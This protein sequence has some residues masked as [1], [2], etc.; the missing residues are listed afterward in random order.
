[1]GGG[2]IHHDG[3]LVAVRIGVD[4]AHRVFA[5]LIVDEQFDAA[6]RLVA[7]ARTHPNAVRVP[8]M[9]EHVF[10]IVLRLGLSG[11][12]GFA[13]CVGAAFRN[14]IQSDERKRLLGINDHTVV[15]DARRD[16]NRIGQGR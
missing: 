8:K 13:L 12:L 7:N 3:G 1:M 5:D 2:E 16:S 10:G 14:K 15:L 4:P 11:F 6:A 9:L